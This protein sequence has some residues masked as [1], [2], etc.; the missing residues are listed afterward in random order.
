MTAR[1]RFRTPSPALTGLTA[2]DPFGV[3][4]CE[5]EDPD[6]FFPISDNDPATD[7]KR[8]CAGCPVVD[9]CLR[10]ALE[11]A[12][13]HGVW[14]GTTPADRRSMVRALALQQHAA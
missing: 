6:L 2:A 7:A 4:P 12:E 3:R 13:E 10:G 9:A 8:V 5:K 14:G 1:R 11:R